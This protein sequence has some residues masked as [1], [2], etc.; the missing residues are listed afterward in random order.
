MKLAS[1]DIGTN[2]TR[3]LIADHYNNKFIPL[4]RKMIITRLGRGLEQ[5]NIILDDSAVRTLD[6]VSDYC[7][8]ISSYDVKRYRAVGTSTLREASNSRWFVSYIYENSGIKIDII[9]GKEEA[10]LSFH[11][12]VRGIGFNKE[13]PGSI[14]VVDI[15]GGS[16]EFILGSSSGS[17][18]FTESIN[19]GCVNLTEKFI[20]HSTPDRENLT[21]MHRHIKDN[22]KKVTGMINRQRPISIIGVAGTITAL[23]A[24]DLG[25]KKYDSVKIH[26]HVLSF[27][28]IKEIY[29]KLCS[30]SLEERKKITGLNP[31]RADIIIGGTAIVIE[32]LK[33]L[34]STEIMTSE[35]DILDGIIYSLIDF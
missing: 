5:N 14:L 31:K 19:I 9:S 7:S 29:K 1:I 26:Q 2:S 30:L 28:K 25:L 20:R 15:G 8:L 13:H 11:G 6:P 23:A 21:G 3:L 33:L 32:V 18:R 34:E 22:L 17:I 10:S 16:T 4:E 27:R 35:K 12:A 24:I